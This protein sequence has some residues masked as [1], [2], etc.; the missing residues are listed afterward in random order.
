MP[1][2]L[3]VFFSGLVSQ[4]SELSVLDS[5]QGRSGKLLALALARQPFVETLSVRLLKKES[6]GQKPGPVLPS[7]EGGPCLDP[8]IEALDSI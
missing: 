5:G 4:N 8:I 3:G 2:F 7:Q 1:Q 6:H